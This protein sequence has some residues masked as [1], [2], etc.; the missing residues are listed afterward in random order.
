MTGH[1]Q[2]LKRIGKLR[3]RVCLAE[4]RNAGLGLLALNLL[5][6]NLGPLAQ[7][8]TTLLACC[9]LLALFAFNLRLPLRVGSSGIFWMAFAAALGVLVLLAH[10]NQRVVQFALAAVAI[11]SVAALL[12]A[13][14]SRLW[15]GRALVMAALAYATVSLFFTSV[16]QLGTLMAAM[17]AGWSKF[18]GGNI[19]HQAVVDGPSGVGGGI[20][21]SMWCYL[22]VLGVVRRGHRA[23][24]SRRLGAA[25]IALL[26]A[27]AAFLYVQ[28]QPSLM[29]QSARAQFFSLA[30]FFALCLPVVGYVHAARPRRVRPARGSVAGAMPKLEGT[31]RAWASPLQISA[32][33]LALLFVTSIA[34]AV[35]P[36]RSDAHPPKVLFLND[37]FLDWDRPLY[38]R[39]GPFESGMFGSLVD[40]LQGTGASCRF[41]RDLAAESLRGADV[42]V[43]I[44]PTNRWHA[45]QLQAVWDYVAGGGSLLVLGD[46]TDI[47]GS[48]APLDALLAPVNI[49]FNFDSGFPARPEWR[50]CLGAL[51]HPLTLRVQR[52]SDAVISVGATLDVAAPAFTVVRGRYG[53]ADLG[54]QLN[55][56]GAYLGDYRYQKGEQ[57]GDVPL[58]AAAYHGRGKVLVFGD[59]SP[60]QNG[61][62]AFSF[63]SF[64]HYVFGWL[65]T[66]DW[67][68]WGVLKWAW[69]LLAMVSVACLARWGPSWTGAAGGVTLAA[70]VALGLHI[71]RARRTPP[72]LNVR[73]ALIDR[74]HAN[75]ISL[76]PLQPD[77][78]GP[79]TITLL[80]NRL[81]P[82]IMNEW[83][84]QE[85]RRA[86]VLVTTAPAQRF[87]R[88][89]LRALS[90][91]VRNGGL[92]L[93][94]C[95]WEEKGNATKALLDEFGFDILRVPLGPYPVQRSENH[96]PGQAQFIN[97]WPVV[98]TEPTLKAAFAEASAAY[99]PPLLDRAQSQQLAHL[100]SPLTGANDTSMARS[101]R[102]ESTIATN[103]VRVLFQTSDGYPVVVARRI[104][105]GSVVVIGD[106]FFLGNDNLENLQY[107]RKGNLLFLKHLFETTPW[108][109]RN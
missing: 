24:S 56:Q 6:G 103:E 48:K 86:T 54:N 15:N 91:F 25:S 20:L 84:E 13:L 40:Y 9:S 30:L 101:T 2:R 26:A 14:R 85:L 53:F 95:G 46:H 33:A 29:P 64:V 71:E 4:V 70:A 7:E 37:G 11:R 41:N 83:S 62:L 75:R 107:H 80:R 79:L 52:A 78:V 51:I 39:Y 59:T 102:T 81:L 36:G 76:A 50:D 82:L 100:L 22:A 61:A 1:A 109:R 63:S 94:N 66:E 31:E 65:T 5:A 23:F 47:M 19:L 35:W 93:I 87:S 27:N 57:L 89:E 12:E 73:V 67:R 34:L 3:L 38:G 96:L 69:G 28:N 21:T 77:S 98:V 60:F 68:H 18:V 17:A 44:N 105:E 8:W 106:T 32:A 88:T 108:K 99:R 49:R 16:P 72:V 92:L 42:L 55:V 90:Q 43:I 74:T 97:A 10:T 45:G 104:G 58:V